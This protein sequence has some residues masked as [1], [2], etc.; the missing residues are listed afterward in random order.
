[1]KRPTY[2]TVGCPWDTNIPLYS[3]PINLK[4]TNTFSPEVEGIFLFDNYINSDLDKYPKNIKKYGWIIE[5]KDIIP[6]LIANIKQNYNEYSTKFDMIFTHDKELL[7]LGD[8]MKFAKTASCSTWIEDVDIHKKTKLVSM[9]ASSKCMCE[10]HKYRLKQINRFK[11]S[12]DLYGRGFNPIDKKE[13]GL[14]DYMFSIAIE[15]SKYETYFTEKISDCFATGTI[16]IYYGSPDIH[17]YFNIDG[18]ILLNDNFKI[19]NLSM[20]LY[21]SKKEAIIDNFERIKY[22]KLPEDELYER[23]IKSYD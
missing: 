13:T 4:W 14:K 1:M 18:I 3:K 10:G 16:P 21:E 22:M 17:E 8:K 2:Y 9:I 7:T 19:E 12:V 11:N 15:N 20:E 5:S 6:N 23:W